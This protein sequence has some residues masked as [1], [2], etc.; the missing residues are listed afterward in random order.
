[1]IQISNRLNQRIWML[2]AKRASIACFPV[3]K[4]AK[5]GS[6]L[7]IENVAVNDVVNSSKSETFLTIK[8]MKHSEQRLTIDIRSFEI[9]ALRMK[10]YFPFPC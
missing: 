8:S 3:E 7:F 10:T 5:N 2:Y 1:M 6:K 9:H 4:N